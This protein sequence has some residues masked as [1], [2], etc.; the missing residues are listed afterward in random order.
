M[1]G[2][3]CVNLFLLFK[4]N[5]MG[6]DIALGGA[7]QRAGEVAINLGGQMGG[8]GRI[9]AQRLQDLRAA[10]F[11][12]GAVLGDQ[13][14]GVAHGRAMAGIQNARAQ[15]FD[16]GQRAIV[17]AQIAIGGG[18]QRRGPAHD[19]IAAQ[20]RIANCETQ[21]IAKMSRRMQR[22]DRPIAMREC[23]AIAQ[24]LIGGKAV[25]DAL[26]S[27]RHTARRQITHHVRAPG[28]GRAKGIDRRARSI[29]QRTRPGGMVKMGMRDEDMRDPLSG[30]EPV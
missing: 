15:G 30:G 14:Q 7:V 2:C 24:P 23:L 20:H 9:R 21:M 25:I 8:G 13:G 16:L 19:Q 26:A 18:N 22:R 3:G 28:L 10:G 4:F 6:E 5:E 27:T 29:R 11:A 12:V 1:Q 17:I